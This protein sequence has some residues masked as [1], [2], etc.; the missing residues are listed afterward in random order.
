MADVPGQ[1]FLLEA[2]NN[3][4]GTILGGSNFPVVHLAQAP[5][6]PAVNTTLADITEA[7][8]DGYASKTITGYDTPHMVPTGQAVVQATPLLSW[9]PTGSTTPNTIA[10]FVVVDHAGNVVSCGKF[11]AP[12][13]VTG[14][15]TP[16]AFVWG[17][18]TAPWNYTSTVLP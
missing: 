6:T 16:V 4:V 14:P 18:G 2:L 12:I 9:T 11:P 1:A 3:L 5:F 17:L 13:T 10:G 8:F 7:T 15:T